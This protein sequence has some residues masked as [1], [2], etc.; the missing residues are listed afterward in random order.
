MLSFNGIGTIYRGES[1]NL[2]GR[3]LVSATSAIAPS[4]TPNVSRSSATLD[5][6]TLM[7][8]L[9]VLPGFQPRSYAHII[10]PLERSKITLVDL[11]T[12]DNLEIA[13]RA[14]VPPTDLRRLTTHVV[15]ALHKDVGFE[16]ACD[17]DNVDEPNSSNNIEK[18]LIPGPSTK[19]DLSR[20]SA[21]STL[22]PA[23]DELLNGGLPTGY[24][25]EVTGER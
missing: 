7:D 2:I 18:S 22:D 15:K 21:I 17:A 11:I 24:L 25:T 6:V 1:R 14:H 8:L 13:K 20:W 16:E 9:S 12:L 3:Q 10:P 5:S 19:L 23:L 4:L